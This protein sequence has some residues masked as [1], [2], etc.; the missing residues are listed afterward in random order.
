LRTPGTIAFAW[1]SLSLGACGGY[2][3][4]ASDSS[5]G[6]GGGA[7][8]SSV[9]ELQ[10]LMYTD[11]ELPVTLLH[12]GDPIE[13]WHAPQ[14]GHVVLAG[15]RVRGLESNTI[16]IEATL[17][18][19]ESGEVVG[20]HRRTVVME[21]VP[22]DPEWMQNDRR[23]RS[24]VAHVAVC[25]RTGPGDVVGREHLLDVHVTELYAD[26][27]EGFA[28]VRVIPTCFQSDPSENALCACECAENYSAGKCL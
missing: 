18:D 20:T 5:G 14:S 1:C 28:T 13:L 2:P 17:R 23:T 15:A 11:P 22:E 21:V 16:E 6:A 3:E 25:P 4:I 9:L 27:T 19:A 26:F 10:P 12:D 24:Q 7:G 8:T